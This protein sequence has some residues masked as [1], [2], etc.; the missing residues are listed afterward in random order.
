VQDL[1]LDWSDTIAIIMVLHQEV[2]G[3]E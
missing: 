3:H 2:D 1:N